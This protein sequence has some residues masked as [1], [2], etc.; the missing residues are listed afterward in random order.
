MKNATKYITVMI[1]LIF[2]Q[3]M[4][5]KMQITQQLLDYDLTTNSVEFTQQATSPIDGSLQ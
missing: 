5:H 2:V 1:H 3:Y 4:K